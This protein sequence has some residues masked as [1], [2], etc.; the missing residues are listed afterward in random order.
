MV[1]A[2]FEEAVQKMELD[3]LEKHVLVQRFIPLLKEYERRCMFYAIVFHVCRF[4]VT[5]GS[6]IVPAL[7]SIQ[8][9]DTT[10]TTMSNQQD[11]A[12]QIY[13]AT[14]AISLLVTTSNGIATVFKIE[15]KYYYLHTTLEQ[16]RSEGWQFVMLTGK[17]S[18]FF[19][20]PEKPTHKNQYVY[21]C[22][23]IE[24]IKMK[25]VTEEYFKIEDQKDT[26]SNVQKNNITTSSIAQPQSQA[27]SNETTIG[28]TEQA[29]QVIEKTLTA[30]S[31]DN[32]IPPTPLNA[33]LQQLLQLLT[34][35]GGRPSDNKKTGSEMPVRSTM[36]SAT[37]PK[38]PFLPETP[39][40]LSAAQ[41]SDRVGAEISTTSLE[42]Q[43]KAKEDP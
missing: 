13:W 6:L 25:Q 20:N 33:S 9:T 40:Q 3:P 37:A 8:Y 11:F 10:S 34:V 26:H 36:H 43:S 24:K 12:Y 19:T 38:E 27:H 15:K 5:V 7:L 41:S 23:T 22:H 4:L 2:K 28:R 32:L 16:L 35:D 30:L 39:Q 31:P 18:G 14:W 1:T 21:F 42:Q 29:N 17:Y